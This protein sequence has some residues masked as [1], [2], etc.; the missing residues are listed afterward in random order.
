MLFEIIKLFLEESMARYVSNKG[1]KRQQA[2]MQQLVPVIVVAVIAV[3]VLVV[4]IAPSLA[5]PNIDRTTTSKTTSLGDANSPVK[6][7]EFG[8]YQCPACGAFFAQTEPGL[9]T[10]YINTGKVYFTFTP[11]SFIGAESIAAAQ[12]AYC[13][14]DQGKFWEY[15]DALYNNQHGENQGGFSTANLQGFAQNLG[16]DMTTFNTCTSSGKYASLV[17]DNVVYGQTMKVNSTPSFLVD[18]KLV[19]QDALIQAVDAELKAKGK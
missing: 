4:L 6:V 5:K 3:I 17:S 8:D 9:V 16:L 12:A 15:H 2:K 14:M 19:F 7:E 11:F 18:G 1:R 10:N 13:A